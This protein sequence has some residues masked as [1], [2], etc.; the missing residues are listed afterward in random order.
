M[1]MSIDYGVWDHIYVSDDVTSPFVDTPSLFGMRHRV[2]AKRKTKKL[3]PYKNLCQDLLK[4]CS[5]KISRVCYSRTSVE[6]QQEKVEKH[7]TFV[8]KHAK[9]MKHFG[10]LRR[11]DDSQ[12]Y[13]SD[14]PHL[15]CEES[16]NYL[17]IL[18]I[19]FEIVEKHA[20]MEGCFRQFFSNIRT[21]NE[22]YQNAFDREL[23]LLKERVRRSA[24]AQM[25]G[26]MKELE[27]EERQKRLG[28]GGLDLVEVYEGLP[29]ENRIE[30]MQ[31]S[32]DEKSSEMLQDVMNKLNPEEG[33]CHLQRCIDSGLWVPDLQEED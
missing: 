12:K 11:W 6:T 32:F 9:E 19:D 27:E 18:C 16:A 5:A 4:H 24:Q 31:R 8:E 29:K 15:V 23:D 30:E 10:M 22:Q 33:R 3:R 21:E 17:V 20:L 14:N 2:Y 1:K 26:T 28:P 13:L 7:K 25:E